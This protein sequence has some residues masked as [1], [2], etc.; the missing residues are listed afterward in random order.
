MG[1]VDI[2]KAGAA[3]GDELDTDG[4]ENIEHLF[5]QVVVDKRADNIRPG[6]FRGSPPWQSVREKAQRVP[7]LAAQAWRKWG[8]RSDLSEKQGTKIKLAFQRSP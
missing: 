4:G 6:S 3:H 7:R 1:Q 8:Q 5:T 2:V